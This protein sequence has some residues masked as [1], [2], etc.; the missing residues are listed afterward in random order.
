MYKNSLKLLQSILFML[1]LIISTPILLLL[2]W[3]SHLVEKPTNERSDSDNE[4]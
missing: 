4:S 2:A 3:V 1:L